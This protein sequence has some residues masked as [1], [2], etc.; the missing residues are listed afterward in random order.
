MPAEGRGAGVKQRRLL[1]V[2]LATVP[3]VDWNLLVGLIPPLAPV[4]VALAGASRGP[5]RL[6]ADLK[7]DAEVAK[8]LPDDGHARREME[9]LLLQEVR[10]LRR[11]ASG[12]R[13]LGF[14]FM[15][16]VGTALVGY[17]AIW[18][19]RQEAWWTVAMGI[20]AGL[21]TL[22]FLY[23]IFESAEKV[24]RDEKGKRLKDLTRLTADATP[25]DLA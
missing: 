13:Q 4:A 12:R 5:G 22:P 11:Y 6:R 20:L 14:T 24:P 25:G 23:G 2:V 16:I 10:S 8:L 9:G 1:S 21:S 7:H 18:L 3:D 17:L 19:L 15:A